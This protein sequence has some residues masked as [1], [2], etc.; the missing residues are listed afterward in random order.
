MGGPM[1][2]CALLRSGLACAVIVVASVSESFAANEHVYTHSRI[3]G[4]PLTNPN[5]YVSVYTRS[6][7]FLPF[8]PVPGAQRQLMENYNSTDIPGYPPGTYQS[9]QFRYELSDHVNGDE[10]MSVIEVWDSGTSSFVL[11]HAYPAFFYR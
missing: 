4:N 11:L 10:Y 9:H 8:E 3:G 6:N 7:P 2:H 5:T 1:G